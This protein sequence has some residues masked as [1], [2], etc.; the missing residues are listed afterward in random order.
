MDTQSEW[1]RLLDL[2]AEAR[3]LLADV[4]EQHWADWLAQQIER[5][6][7]LRAAGIASLLEGYGGMA[8]FSDLILHQR[9]GHEID[10]DDEERLN[11]RLDDLR[12]AILRTAKRIDE[13]A[14]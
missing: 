7:T 2:L 12:S 3:S 9:N 13:N 8:S 1:T 14:G 5:L 6:N 4:G 10:P 11:A